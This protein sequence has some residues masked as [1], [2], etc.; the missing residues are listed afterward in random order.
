VSGSAPTTGGE[1]NDGETPGALLEE[2]VLQ[3]IE[4]LGGGE[5]FLAE[6]FTGFISDA[7]GLKE[8]V[9][10]EVDAGRFR[11]ARDELHA[12][13]GSAGS[14][15]A[16]ALFAACGRLSEL[17]KEQRHGDARA[18]A[19]ALASLIDRTAAAFSARSEQARDVRA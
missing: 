3:H 1:P 19:A 12:L 13:R 15:G 14:V 5:G 16:Q 2:R 17:C 7:H 10:A 4:T 18:A 9:V 6:L 11:E 8:K